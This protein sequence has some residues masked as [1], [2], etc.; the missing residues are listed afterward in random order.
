[1]TLT[2]VSVSGVRLRLREYS[3]P[4][5]HFQFDQLSPHFQKF[6]CSCLLVVLT[7]PKPEPLLT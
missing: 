7:G 6:S 1:M 2:E 4:H 5:H 3:L